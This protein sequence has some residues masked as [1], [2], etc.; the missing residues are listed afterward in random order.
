MKDVFLDGASNTPIDKRVLKAMRPYLTSKFVGNSFSAHNFGTQAFIAIEEARDKVAEATKAKPTEV[1]FTSGATEGNNWVIRS[2]AETQLQAGRPRPRV[3]CGATE[4]SSVLNACKRLKDFGFDVTF[5]KP[6]KKG[7]ITA[8]SAKKVI[9][10]GTCLVCIMAVNNETGVAN[11]VNSISKFAKQQGAEVLVDCTQAIS[12]G[13]KT[14]EI[15][16]KFP[17]A[18]YFTFSAHK[19]Y[20]PT[21]VGCLIAREGV[22][23]N[24][25]LFGGAQEFGK[26]GGTSNTAA[27]VGM[28]KAIE[29]LH[30]EDYSHHFEVLNAYLELCLYING[31]RG[32]VN[33]EPDHKNILS[34][35]FSET[36]NVPNL[37]ASL[38]T[39]YIAVSAGSA[40]DA[41][42]DD[43]EGFNPSHVLT[44]MKLSE[45]SIRNTI[46]VSF[47]KYTTIKDIQKLLQ[48]IKNIAKEN[49]MKKD[50]TF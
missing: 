17:Y 29:I 21:G 43:I 4:H 11:D 30:Q 9:S 37:A 49:E 36:V 50:L 33:T 39:E 22:N 1:Y 47:T 10:T 41:E 28:G 18:N 23:L 42:H 44:A 12:L 46:R 24:P 34:I 45:T 14:V 15:C 8:A 38:A 35:D 48:A 7:K 40:C 5:V 25:L 26:R 19:F 13:G 27:I 31:T 3:V 20:G 32:K 16:E 2:I 6:N